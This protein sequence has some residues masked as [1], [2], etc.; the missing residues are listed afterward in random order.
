M[1][2]KELKEVDPERLIK[3]RYVCVSCGFTHKDVGY[4]GKIRIPTPA[5][6]AAPGITDP[7]MLF[8]FSC[9]E[10]ASQDIMANRLRVDFEPIKTYEAPTKKRTPKKP[11]GKGGLFS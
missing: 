3:P 8:C 7:F 1:T 6:E 2:N 5:E 4:F 9:F 11:T 10:E